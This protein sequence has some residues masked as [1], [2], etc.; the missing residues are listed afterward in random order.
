MSRRGTR[1]YGL[2]KE[3]GMTAETPRQLDKEKVRKPLF[4]SFLSTTITVYGVHADVL[5]FYE[6]ALFGHTWAWS[7]SRSSLLVE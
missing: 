4:P 1:I 5:R 6:Y 2:R 7:R 3:L